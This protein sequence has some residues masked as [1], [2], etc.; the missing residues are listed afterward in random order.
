MPWVKAA[1]FGGSRPFHPVSQPSG[2]T[3]HAR[4]R[5]LRLRLR[6]CS[7]AICEVQAQHADAIRRGQLP[8]L[9][10]GRGLGEKATHRISLLI[11][12][13]GH[14]LVVKEGE[15]FL[16]LPCCEFLHSRRQ[17][18]GRSRRVGVLTVGK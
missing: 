10:C 12:G 14:P 2:R 13:Q 3:C 4:S 6:R 17:D 16:G 11:G 7:L 8:R 15:E 1:P 5:Q 9:R 18:E